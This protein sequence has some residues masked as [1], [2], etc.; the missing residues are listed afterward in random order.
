MPIEQAEL[1]ATFQRRRVD[2]APGGFMALLTVTRIAISADW[3][4]EPE[5]R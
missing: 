4:V 3:S 2:G 5:R 1:D